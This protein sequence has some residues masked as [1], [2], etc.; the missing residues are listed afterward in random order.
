MVKNHTFQVCTFIRVVPPMVNDRETHKCSRFT[1]EVSVECSATNGASVSQPHLLEP[2]D[3]FRERDRK[4]E[5]GRD[6]GG[7][8]ET[9][10]WT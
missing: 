7:L 2:G 9:V 1:E 6:Q 4:I 3:H 5:R 8:R 10:F